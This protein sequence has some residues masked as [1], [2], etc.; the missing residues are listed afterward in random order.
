[1]SPVRAGM[2]EFLF[3]VV[4]L[5]LNLLLVT[6]ER[7]EW[8]HETGWKCYCLVL[9]SCWPPPQMESIMPLPFEQSLLMC[10]MSPLQFHIPEKLGCSKKLEIWR[11]LFLLFLSYC[12]PAEVDHYQVR[13]TP[14]CVIPRILNSLQK[15]A[16]FPPSVLW[17]QRCC[18]VS[19]VPV[20][21][22]GP[23]LTAV[24]AD[25]AAQM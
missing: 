15:T 2:F 11:G 12:S 7:V 20:A 19:V 9:C 21:S 22:H 8:M 5:S 1:M 3:I 16:L 4:A 18:A 17:N 6:A 13:E 23:A 14:T 25:L 24:D 10:F